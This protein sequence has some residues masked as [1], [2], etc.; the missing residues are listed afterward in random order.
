MTTKEFAKNQFNSEFYARYWF[1][2]LANFHC[3]MKRESWRFDEADVI[4]FL[5]SMVKEKMPTWKRLTIV[6]NLIW[7]RNNILKTDQP[8]LELVR[9]K[10]QEDCSGAI[11]ERR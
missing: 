2:E 9:T 1:T 5:K 4:A 6:K 7:Y 11:G 3:V 8:S 10:M